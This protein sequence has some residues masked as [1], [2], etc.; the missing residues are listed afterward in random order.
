MPG[1]APAKIEATQRKSDN[2]ATSPG[3]RFLTIHYYK[4]V[5]KIARSSH[6]PFYLR[7]RA[8]LKKDKRMRNKCDKSS[9]YLWSSF[10]IY[11]HISRAEAAHRLCLASFRGEKNIWE[12]WSKHASM[13]KRCLDIRA[14]SQGHYWDIEALV[15]SGCFFFLLTFKASV[16]W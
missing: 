6:R 10:C 12:A 13:I 3:A 11:M 7:I 2:I 14:G 15:R 5:Y 4:A 1:H 16:Y 9:I 8:F